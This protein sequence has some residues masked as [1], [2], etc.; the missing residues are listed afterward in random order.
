MQP[1]VISLFSWPPLMMSLEDMSHVSLAIMFFR[2]N[3]VRAINNVVLQPIIFLVR[4]WNCRVVASFILRY[5]IGPWLLSVG[6]CNC[7]LY[8]SSVSML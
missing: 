2:S 4:A 8:L 3:V 6:G 1:K 7:I 5:D